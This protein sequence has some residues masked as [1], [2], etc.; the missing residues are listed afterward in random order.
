MF[1]AD[2]FYLKGG[3]SLHIYHCLVKGGH[4]GSGRFVER[5]LVIRA[6]SILEAMQIAKGFGGVKKGHCYKNGTSVLQVRLVN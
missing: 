5:K 2:K 1:F 6:K 4:V 3:D